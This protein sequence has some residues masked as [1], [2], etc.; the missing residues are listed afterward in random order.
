[1]A[2]IELST[3]GVTVWYAPE[4]TAGTR[5]TTGYIKI[6]GIKSTPDLNTAPSALETTTLEATEF[7]TYISGLKDPGG[8]LEFT[9]NHTEDFKEKWDTFVLAS[10]TAKASQKSVWIAIIIP[11]L[12][13]SFYMAVDPSPMGLSATAVD[14]VLETTVY[15]APKKIAG[16]AAKPTT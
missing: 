15:V 14:A 13:D 5:P 8:S 16:W 2:A 10:E 6:P 7:K 12:E 4:S 11:G 1:M 9:A 3:A